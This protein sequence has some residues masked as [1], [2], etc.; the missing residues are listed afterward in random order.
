MAR[1]FEDLHNIEQLDDR[2]LRDLVRE[3][4]AAHNGARHRR[5]H[6][7][8]SKDGRVVL[9][10]PRGHGRGA[11]HRRAC[12]HRRPRHQRTSPTSSCRSDPSRREPDGHRRASRGRGPRRG[13]APRRPCRSRSAPRPSTWPMSP[14]PTSKARRTCGDVI[15]T[16]RTW[17]PPERPTPEGMSGTDAA[18]EDMGSSTEDGARARGSR[19]GRRPLRDV[20]SLGRDCQPFTVHSRARAVSSSMPSFL[21]RRVTFAAAHRYRIADWSDERN[22]ADVRRVRAP[23]LSRPQLRVR[24][25]RHRRDRSGHRLHRRSR[26]ARRGAAARGAR[27][28]STIATSTSTCR[29]S[30]TADSCRR[31]R[32]SLASSAERVQTAL[33]ARLA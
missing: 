11:S 2:E 29:S 5:H 28:D 19:F 8:R 16:R 25:H 27:R 14:T 21:T 24:R 13:P 15:E 26:R 7:R 6:G 12:P 18:P 20:S 32:S 1:D 30:P 3:H 17:N 4:L 10:G 22:A 31:A 23:E 9:V 33:G